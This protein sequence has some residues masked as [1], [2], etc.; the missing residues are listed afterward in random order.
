MQVE[1]VKEKVTEVKEQAAAD[2]AYI[3]NRDRKDNKT[4]TI[5]RVSSKLVL[6]A[7]IIIILF[8]HI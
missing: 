2:I 4:A 6:L 8:L 3:N 7:M 1:D 5:L